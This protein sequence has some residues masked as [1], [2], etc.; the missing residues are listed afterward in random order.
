M[1]SRTT[2]RTALALSAG[3]MMVAGLAAWAARPE[4]Y[5]QWEFGELRVAQ[6]AI[7][8]R[9]TRTNGIECFVPPREL[10]SSGGRAKMYYLDW[11]S[12]VGWE[13]VDVSQTDRDWVY[14]MRRA[15]T[16]TP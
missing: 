16:P 7:D 4:P 9:F 5:F 14:L 15:R 8:I 2:K 12:S 3:L 13:L 6:S 11:L 10:R 1:L